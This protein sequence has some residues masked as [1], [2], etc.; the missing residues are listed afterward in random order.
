VTHASDTSPDAA[1]YL[2]EAQRKRT[3]AE[4]LRMVGELNALARRVAEA[5]I[6]CEH[7]AWSDLD[8]KAEMARRLLGPELAREVMAEIARRESTA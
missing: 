1:R 4:R 8:V 3:P 6:R 2:L 7:P 5:A